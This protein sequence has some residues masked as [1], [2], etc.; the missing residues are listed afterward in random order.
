MGLGAQLGERR[1]SGPGGNAQDDEPTAASAVA[2]RLAA[3]RMASSLQLD[4]KGLVT[5]SIELTHETAQLFP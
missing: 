2:T 4:V 3:A 5:P 1:R